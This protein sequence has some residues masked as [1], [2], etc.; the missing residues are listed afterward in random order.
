MSNGFGM[1]L[2][3]EQVVLQG[4]ALALVALCDKDTQYILS[5][6]LLTPPHAVE[7]EHGYR[8][9]EAALVV[10]PAAL[11]WTTEWTLG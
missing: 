10:V 8:G 9:L 5:G 2:S 4:F 3:H 7:V 11:E 1:N 6:L